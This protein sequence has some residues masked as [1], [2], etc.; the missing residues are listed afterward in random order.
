MAIILK[1]TGAEAL[2]MIKEYYPKDWEFIL[3]NATN[4]I[5]DKM[6]KYKLSPLK[7]YQKFVIVGDCSHVSKIAYFAATS[8]LHEQNKMTNSEKAKKI[9][10]L[11][12]KRHLIKEQIVALESDKTTNYEDKKILRSYYNKLQQKTNKEYNELLNSFEV[13][14]PRRIIFQTELFR[15]DN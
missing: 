10:E 1:Y 9:I 15:N 6:V 4:F 3:E 7:A 11:D 8:M 12:D 14:E 2:E 13:V 5:K